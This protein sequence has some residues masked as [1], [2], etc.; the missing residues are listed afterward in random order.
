MSMEVGERQTERSI[1]NSQLEQYWCTSQPGACKYH[2][3]TPGKMLEVVDDPRW[4][5]VRGVTL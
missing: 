5:Y 3:N 1:S 2:E 4:L